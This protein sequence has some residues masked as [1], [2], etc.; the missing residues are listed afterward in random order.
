M[1]RR[2]ER[3]RNLRKGIRGGQEEG[4]ILGKGGGQE[5]GGRNISGSEGGHQGGRGVVKIMMGAAN[6]L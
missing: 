1:I 3:G 5:E 6:E 4:G 2:R